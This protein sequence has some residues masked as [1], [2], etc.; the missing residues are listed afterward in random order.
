[1]LL[2]GFFL[3][4]VSLVKSLVLA[5]KTQLSHEKYQL[6]EDSVPTMGSLIR[7]NPSILKLQFLMADV[8][9]FIIGNPQ[10]NHLVGGLPTP[11]EKNISQLG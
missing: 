9:I 5:G 4:H 6:V 2:I 10:Y 7:T 8:V 3:K 1:V 11:L